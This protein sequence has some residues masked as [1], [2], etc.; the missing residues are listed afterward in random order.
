MFE[1]FRK[2]FIEYDS[3]G[4]KIVWQIRTERLQDIPEMFWQNHCIRWGIILSVFGLG[5][6]SADTVLLIFFGKYSNRSTLILV[7]LAFVT[8][9]LG[10]TYWPVLSGH[11]RTHTFNYFLS[12]SQCPACLA[13]LRGQAIE[14]DGCVV[15]PECHAA[16]KITDQ[17]SQ[18]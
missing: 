1:R 12:R 7:G 6:F 14:D 15:C 8:V 11:F 3:R 17:V 4:E 5:T 13:D 2:L 9:A 16:W 18:P 10:L